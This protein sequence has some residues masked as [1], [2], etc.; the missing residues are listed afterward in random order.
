M[1]NEDRIK[2]MTRLAVFEKEHGRENEIASRFYKADYISYYMIWTG[3]MTTIAYVL[4]LGLFFALNFERYM[5]NMHKMHLWEQGKIM[6]A[7]Y[8][9]ILT[10]MLMLSWF[11]YRRR[12]KKAKKGLEEY[13]D[14]LHEL[15]KIYN[16]E[17]HREHIKTRQE[18][19]R[20]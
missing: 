7:I 19:E 10:A 2:V 11:I 1:L 6:I 8:V 13:C 5:E 20:R 16:S 15:E 17:R 9:I 3:I 12:Y 18:A 14:L 4:G